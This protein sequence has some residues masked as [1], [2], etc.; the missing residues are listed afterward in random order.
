MIAHPDQLLPNT[1]DSTETSPSKNGYA[2][3]YS[4]QSFWQKLG[5]FAQVAGRE[6]TEKALWLYYAVQDPS[7][8]GWA[9]AVVYG[10]LGYF[11]LPTDALP[12]FVPGIGFTDDLGALAAAIAVVIAHVTPEVKEKARRQLRHWFQTAQSAQSAS[13]G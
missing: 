8:P 1:S 9:K 6:V 10:A 13:A 11:V 3:A 2:Q 12:D 5:G 7:M 4:E